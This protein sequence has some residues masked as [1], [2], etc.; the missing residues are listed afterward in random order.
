MSGELGLL[1]VEVIRRVPEPVTSKAAPVEFT[2]RF[3]VPTDSAFAPAEMFKGLGA[4]KET[5]ANDR[6]PAVTAVVPEYVF[7]AV[8]TNLPAPLLLRPPIPALTGS[9]RFL[10]LPAVIGA[11]PA[12]S[13]RT[14]A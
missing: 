4:E 10:A 3:S 5:V 7:A 6:V 9:I 13:V 12:A 2:I 8:N 11:V 14:I 1:V